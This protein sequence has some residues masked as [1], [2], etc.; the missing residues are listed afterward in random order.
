MLRSHSVGVSSVTQNKVACQKIHITSF[1]M[2]TVANRKILNIFLLNV[3]T[4]L[5]FFDNLCPDIYI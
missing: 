3:L 2:K 4:S 1:S 5:E